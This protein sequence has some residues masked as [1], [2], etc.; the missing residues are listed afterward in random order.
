MYQE[1]VDE[2]DN[3]LDLELANEDTTVRLPGV[4]TEITEKF[5]K[6]NGDAMGIVGIEYQGDVAEFV[7]FPKDWATYKFLWKDM[8][9]AIFSLT[10]TQKGVKFNDAFE[11]RK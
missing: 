1:E 3:Y 6:K 4:I 11:L 5:T 2:C 10:K 8:K 9:V 7:V